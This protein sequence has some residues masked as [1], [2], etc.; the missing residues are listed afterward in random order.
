MPGGGPNKIYIVRWIDSEERATRGEEGV[1]ARRRTSEPPSR[2][3]DEIL[4]SRRKRPKSVNLKT[5]LPDQE[6]K[7]RIAILE[8]E[9]RHEKN[10]GQVI[11]NFQ[12]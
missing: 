8:T 10:R 7:N 9:L 6:L 5:N 11:L 4:K 12:C 1:Q 2:W 3:K